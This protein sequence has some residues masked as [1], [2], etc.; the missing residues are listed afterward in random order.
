MRFLWSLVTNFSLRICWDEKSSCSHITRKI[1]CT[2]W[3]E[4]WMCWFLCGLVERQGACRVLVFLTSRGSPM[5]FYTVDE[6]LMVVS[7]QQN[8][9]HLNNDISQS[10]Y[11]FCCV[12]NLQRFLAWFS[13]GGGWW[14]PQTRELSDTWE[15]CRQKMMKATLGSKGRVGFRPGTTWY[16]WWELRRET[17]DESWDTTA[18]GIYYISV[19]KC[20]RVTLRVR[21]GVGVGGKMKER[22]CM[23][24]N[25]AHFLVSW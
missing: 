23:S 17:W 7:T 11:L 21:S 10:K 4:E 25:K 19:C 18:W 8:E 1:K 20:V 3:L 24:E 15:I 13:V 12:P 16:L 9:K 6:A 14:L 5:L 2:M 22:L